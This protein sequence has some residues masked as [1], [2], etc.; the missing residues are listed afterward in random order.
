[1]LKF[2]MAGCASCL[3]LTAFGVSGVSAAAL[4]TAFKVHGPSALKLRCRDSCGTGGVNHLQFS[5]GL[6]TMQR[7][8]SMVGCAWCHRS[9]CSPFP[10]SARC[11]SGM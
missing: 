11:K 4:S 10:H 2:S 6:T 3:D 1:M 5:K 7:K 8:S 9:F